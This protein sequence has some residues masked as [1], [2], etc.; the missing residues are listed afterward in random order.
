MLR[1]ELRLR[2]ILTALASVVFA[3][4]VAFAAA[5]AVLAQSA[6]PPADFGAPP[7]GEVP[8]L[9]NDH[10]VYTKP[11]RLKAQRVLAAL[12]R[13]TTILIPLRSMFEQM[14]ATVSYDAATKVV[15]VSKPGS[16]VKVTVGKPEVIINGESRPLDVPPEIYQGR[17]RRHHRRRRRPP[18]RKHQRHRRRRRA[19]RRRRNRRTSISTSR[20]TTSSHRRCTT[21][22]RPACKARTRS[23]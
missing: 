17:R 21:S 11:D 8:I 12:V 16:D 6:M 19:R 10:H 18:R 9:F 23:T 15:D 13:G 14:G 2:A 7:S 4:A 1:E 5:P 3:A 22:S 20:A